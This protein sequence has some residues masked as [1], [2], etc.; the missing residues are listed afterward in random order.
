MDTGD[1]VPAADDQL[2]APTDD[3]PYRQAV[4][5]CQYRYRAILDWAQFHGSSED[6]MR[7][8]ERAAQD[9]E[10]GEFFF[11]RIGRVA[12]T[13]PS[14]VMALLVLRLRLIEEYDTQNV[15]ERMLID[16]ALIAFYHQIRLHELAGNVEARAEHAFFGDTPLR[17]AEWD[18]HGGYQT[19]ADEYL[20]DINQRLLPA[21][22][23]CQRMLMRSLR[24]LRKLRSHHLTIHSAQQ[25][26]VARQ[27][28]VYAREGGPA[29][30]EIEAGA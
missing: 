12:E 2:P 26:N 14:L 18:R 4:R 28:V 5:R 22:E 11:T 23:R 30:P 10:S 21:I 3:E 15:L 6:F 9:I 1:L 19:Q 13:D 8:F 27:Q 20:R 17:W 16:Q 7:A 25:V 29:V 24:E